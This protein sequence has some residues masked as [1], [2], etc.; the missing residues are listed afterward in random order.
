MSVESTL[1]YDNCF[2]VDWTTCDQEFVQSLTDEQKALSE[3]SAT[4]TLRML[5]GYR[6]GGCPSVVRPCKRS[7][8]PESWLVAP[9]SNLI[10]GFGGYGGLSPYVRDGQWYNACGCRNDDC[11]CT[12]VRQVYLPGRVGRV[13]EVQ[14]DGEVLDPSA[15]RVDNW[16]YLVRQDGGDWPVCQDMNL[17]DGE[18]GTFSVTY[19]DGNPVDALGAHVAG[20]LAQEFARACISAD[21]ALPANVQSYTRQG[22]SVQ[23]TPD[24]T[25]F[26][27]G[28]TGLRFVDDWIQ[29][30]NPNS[31]LPSGVYSPDLP[32]GRRTTWSAS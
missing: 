15:Y 20:I 4:Q 5:T 30:W 14:V 21:C 26:P 13:D 3:A 28:R 11:G 2:P 17:P 32:R 8:L 23:M 10:A 25:Q 29:V 18:D 27:G 6:V 9:A 19:L 1:P 12:E 22:I 24:E 31:T 7:C 16:N